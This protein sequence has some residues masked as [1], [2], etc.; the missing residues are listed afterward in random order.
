M[1]SMW[2]VCVRVATCL[3]VLLVL[4]CG[5]D[6]GKAAAGGRPGGDHA[7]RP[8]NGGPSAGGPPPAATV[9][10]EVVRVERRSI[11]SYLET[12]GT[13]E[14][15]NEVNIVARAAGPI[16]ELLAE[17]G[18]RV[19]S[20]EVVARL[21]DREIRAQLEIAKVN[22]AEAE[23][24]F[25]RAQQ[26]ID[27]KLISRE[28]F[29]RARS[30]LESARAQAESTRIQLDY[31]VI[32]APFSGLIIERYVKF[33]QMLTVG[34]ELFRLSDFDPL[35]CPIQIPERELS[36]L[37]LRQTAEL[38]VEAYPGER[39]AAR[40]LRISPVVD[41]ATGTVKVTLAVQGRG[42]LRPGMFASVF[43]RTDVHQG[44]LAIPKAA[45]VLESLGDT[46]Y[47]AVE[48][49]EGMVASRREVRM[50]FQ[51]ADFV[52]VLA[53]V[54]E[55]ENVVVVGQEGLSEGT[56]VSLLPAAGSGQ[57]RMAAGPMATGAP[58]AASSESPAP[59]GRR[60]SFGP[61]GPSA[62]QLEAIKERMRARGLSD[63]QIEERLKRMRQRF[64]GNGGGG[65]GGDGDDGP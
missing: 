1:R 21:D 41:A 23:L 60:P 56:P 19:A 63:E 50:G 5:G 42:K 15:E 30:A 17:E 39:F 20:G 13:L 55:G 31:T 37:T 11:S 59:G 65:Q 4:A 61:E 2:R 29:D 53:G 52:E 45:L 57:G 24:A 3:A 27:L 7:R 33:A 40:V 18:Q 47:V 49:E 32:R 12:N 10:V 28:E 35:L 6:E 62:E 16:V 51:E 25:D 48:A 64:G 36:S 38:T 9:P 14:A 8:G 26:S 44:A 58:P 46:V 34:T 22:L 43:L 54:E